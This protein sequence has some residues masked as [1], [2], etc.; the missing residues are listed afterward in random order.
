MNISVSPIIKPTPVENSRRLE[1]Y[2]KQANSLR[3]QGK[4]Q[5][6]RELYYEV[7]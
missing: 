2:I 6:S 3:A 4:S 1:E 7:L 5:Y